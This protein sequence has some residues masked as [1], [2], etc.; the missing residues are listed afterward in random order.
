MQTSYIF[1]SEVFGQTK[2]NFKS[3]SGFEMLMKI[4]CNQSEVEDFQIVRFFLQLFCDT[5]SADLLIHFHNLDLSP[6]FDLLF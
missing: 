2:C 5:R 1:R 4:F 3:N 6:C